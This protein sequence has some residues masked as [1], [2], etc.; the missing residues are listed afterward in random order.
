MRPASTRL[1]RGE[2]S[3][4][5]P[6]GGEERPNTGRAGC[7]ACTMAGLFFLWRPMTVHTAKPLL[8]GRTARRRDTRQ[9]SSDVSGM[10]R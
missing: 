3:A 6:A 8:K 1:G 9:A 10:Q 5:S 7:G 2:E 4:G